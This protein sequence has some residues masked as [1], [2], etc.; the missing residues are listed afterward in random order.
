[1]DI[2]ENN[3]KPGNTLKVI[4]FIFLL[5]VIAGTAM[6]AYLKSQDMDFGSVAIKD[7][8][9]KTFMSKSAEYTLEQKEFDYDANLSTVFHTYKN[10]IV[11]CS[12]DNIVYVDSNGNEQWT[13]SLSLSNPVVKSAGGYLLVADY[14][15]RTILEFNGKELRWEKELDNKII[16]A[17][18]NSKG[19]VT[20]VHEDERSRGAVSVYDRQGIDCF[21]L[22]KADNFVLSSD[23]SPDG[24]KV[25]INSVDTSSINMNA[26]VEFTDLKG[27]MLS[28]KIEKEDSVFPSVRFMQE[29]LLAVGDSMFIILDGDFNEKLQYNV[30]GKIFSSCI[31]EQKYAVIAANP[32]ESTGVFESGSSGVWV[33]NGEGERVS[34]YNLKGEVKNLKS[35]DDTIAVNL[36]SKLCFINIKG[37][38]LAEY[39]SSYDI[40]DVFFI[41]RREVLVVCN[42]K[43]LVIK[44]I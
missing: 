29:G 44:M 6:V 31:A 21:T 24:K 26:I 3:A 5:L 1:M 20:V 15:A 23:V 22:G 38:L 8:I 4:V 25:F 34:E 27:T 39:S 17:D 7:I 43:F 40:K 42:E 10:Y 16:N 37:E 33:Y 11:K 35:Y 14:G 32:E 41:S 28:A 2:T 13:Y 12:R 36:G 19:Y 18:I 30:K 9:D